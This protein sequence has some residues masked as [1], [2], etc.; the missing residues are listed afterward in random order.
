MIDHYI[1]S[2]KN[3]KKAKDT[4]ELYLPGEIEFHERTRKPEKKGLELS[5]QTGKIA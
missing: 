1:R 4:S 3:L 2:I 5:S